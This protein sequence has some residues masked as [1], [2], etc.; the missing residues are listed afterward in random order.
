MAAVVTDSGT[1]DAS[2]VHDLLDQIEVDIERF[3]GDGAYDQWSVYEALPRNVRP[4]WFRPRR[5]SWSLEQTRRRVERGMPPSP[6]PATSEDANGRRSPAITGRPAPRTRSSATSDSSEAGS[7]A[8][9]LVPK[10]W[11]CACRAMS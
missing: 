10:R 9:I 8:V 2:A 5:R 1:N 3:T 7:D 4:S 11:K 6:A